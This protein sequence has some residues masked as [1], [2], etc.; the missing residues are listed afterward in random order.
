VPGLF[1][2]SEPGRPAR[3]LE[4]EGARECTLD[5]WGAAAVVD[6]YAADS[7]P[8]SPRERR[9]DLAGILVIGEMS[10][11]IRERCPARRLQI[12]VLQV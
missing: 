6:V 5:P 8:G 7:L 11:L 3:E 2:G 10:T 12:Q 9:L 1:R 4:S